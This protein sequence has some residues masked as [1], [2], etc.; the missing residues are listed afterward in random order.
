MKIKRLFGS[1]YT[2]CTLHLNIYLSPSDFKVPENFSKVPAS[3]M[4]EEKA[5]FTIL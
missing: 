2:S 5:W 4:G 3:Y 1:D